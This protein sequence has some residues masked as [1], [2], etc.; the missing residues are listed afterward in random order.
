MV[1]RPI[2]AQEDA[3]DDGIAMLLAGIDEL[4]VPDLKE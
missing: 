4:V 2:L 1:P 3:G